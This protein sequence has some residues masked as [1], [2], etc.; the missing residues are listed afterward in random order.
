MSSLSENPVQDI[1]LTVF[2]GKSLARDRDI[3]ECLGFARLTRIRILINRNRAE[4][5]NDSQA[6]ENQPVN[7]V[8]NGGK[9][10]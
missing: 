8:D 9:R 4:L 10:A 3:A 6:V 5:E 7:N 2:R 1:G